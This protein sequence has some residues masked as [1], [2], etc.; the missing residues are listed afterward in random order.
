[1]TRLVAI[2]FALTLIANVAAAQCTLPYNLTNGQTA[3][4]TQVM[5]NFNA[6]LNCVSGIGTVN[7]GTAGQVAYYGATGTA[8]S[9]ESLS[10]LI[11]SA[12]GSAQG[13]VLYRGT[14]NWA[15]L[16][17]GVAG[18]FLQTQ[19]SSS[20]PQWATPTS[21]SLGTIT[22][23]S[24]SGTTY[25]VGTTDQGKEI[26][27][28]NTSAVTMTLPQAGSTGFP[29]TWASEIYNY[30]SPLVTINTTTSTIDGQSSFY[31]L[32]GHSVW[33]ISD[34]AN[35]QVLNKEITQTASNNSFI[36]GGVGNT[37][38]TTDSNAKYNVVLGGSTNGTGDATNQ[39]IAGGA[40]NTAS[41]NYATVGGGESN[42]ASGINSTVTGGDNNR[43]SG[44]NST[45][46][47]YGNVASGSQSVAAGDSCT[48]SNTSS[49]CMGHQSTASGTYASVFGSATSDRGTSG[50]FVEG[51]N[52]GP[53]ASAAFPGRAQSVVYTLF[54]DTTGSSAVRLTTDGNSAGTSNIGAL[55]P[56][57]A[58]TWNCRITITDKTNIGNVA[59]YTIGDS[60]IIQGTTVGSTT[61]GTGNPTASAGPTAGTLTLQAAPALA[62]DTTNGGFNLS[63]T[64]PSGN[65]DELYSVAVCRA[66]ETQ[67]N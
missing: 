7:S 62:A 23:N 50:A 28:T 6:L 1:V 52:G 53:S 65:S 12:F 41:A 46:I 40:S 17:P 60:L 29:A 36:V 58:V 42:T 27:L 16:S 14:S 30:A 47:G 39:T 8:V 38:N 2:A 22:I 34:G 18:Q 4:A 67:Y 48:A 56:K 3:D 35:W 5:A 55:K 24:Q 51:G 66:V 64:P 31:I 13:S 26:I 63:Y 21:G 57:M 15:A 49:L 54:N 45:A 37:I 59:T 44:Q 19:G 20:N 61:L 43:A 11:D 10:S 32:K 9:G 33:L 25:T